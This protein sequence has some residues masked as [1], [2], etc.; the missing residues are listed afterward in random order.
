MPADLPSEW[1]S[2]AELAALSLPGFPATRQKVAE[3]AY[4]DGWHSQCDQR[5][6]PLVR[7]RAGRGGGH[8]YHISL[9]PLAARHA[10][11]ARLQAANDREIGGE[12]VEQIDGQSAKARGK[13]QERLAIVREVNALIRSGST[14][15]AAVADVMRRWGRTDRTIHRYLKMVGQTDAAPSEQIGRLVPRHGGGRA[16]IAFDQE[17]W[18]VLISDYLRLSKPSWEACYRRMVEEYCEPRGIVAPTSKALLNRLRREVPASVIRARREG[19]EAERKAIPAQE[20]TVADLH[21][22]YAVNID[23]HTFDVF[24]NWGKDH[25]GNDI[26]GRPTLIGLQ[27]VYSRKLLSYRIEETE[28]TLPVRLAFADLFRDY[29][30]PEKCVLD[31]GRA[32]ASKAITGGA[33]TR[34]RFKIK[35]SDFNGVLT[36]LG[37]D[38]RWTLPY[39]G[40]SKPIERAW[41]DLCE[42]IAKHPR[43][44]GAYTGNKPTAKPED[45]GTRAIPIDEFRAFV[46]ERIA[47]HNARKARN[48]E[49]G[50]GLYSFDQV[51]AAS[52][53]AAPIR[54]ASRSEISMALLEAAACRVNVKDSVITLY[55]NRYWSE[56][57]ENLAGKPVVVRFDPDNLH[58]EIQVFDL[59]GRFLCAAPAIQKTGF[60]DQ[61]GAKRRRK[62]E[63][64]AKR[65]RKQAEEALGLL[66]ADQVAELL[67]GVIEPAPVPEPKVV[68]PVRGRGQTAAAL[69]VVS[70]VAE[71]AAPADFIDGFAAGVRHL[72]VVE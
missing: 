36:Q 70:N 10:L 7:R 20:R 68:R 61:E 30:I 72:R 11:A 65:R 48:T 54:K 38:A 24:V 27:D 3:R 31:N 53:A 49:M 28:C 47:R 57:L 13:A 59:V 26:I 58:G 6:M 37:V 16:Q 33:K 9:L 41:K 1:F 43:M 62:L 52:Y 69:K 5:G 56:D 66:E 2:A 22:L 45:Y 55:G 71:Q 19:Q 51:F 64:A 39:R 44:Q 25:K 12:T 32:F 40:S 42:E 60:F 17:A 14:K 50:K 15:T 8:E 23:G 29:G 4:E 21:A 34:F 35:D 18:T 46:A 63:V 67:S